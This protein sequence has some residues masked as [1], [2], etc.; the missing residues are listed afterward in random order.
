MDPSAATVTDTVTGAVST[1]LP[2]KAAVMVISSL[3][4]SE[5][6]ESSRLKLIL[7][8]GVSPSMMVR[9]AGVTV[10]PAAETDPVIS[11]ASASPAASSSVVDRVK[12]PDP[13]DPPAAIVTSKASWPDGI[14]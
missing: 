2:G 6:S 3:S 11:S 10:T 7:E 8:G 1:E 14:E 4:P 9:D 13:A 12:V 5:T